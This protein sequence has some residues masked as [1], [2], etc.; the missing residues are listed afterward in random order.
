[1]VGVK[2]KYLKQKKNIIAVV[3]KMSR[4]NHEKCECLSFLGR[5]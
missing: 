5:F 4:V 2:W 3:S 1:M